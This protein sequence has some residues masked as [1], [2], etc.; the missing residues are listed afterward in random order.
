MPFPTNT[1]LTHRR[2]HGE[3]LYAYF[4]AL[5]FGREEFVGIQTA[6]LDFIDAGSTRYKGMDAYQAVQNGVLAL[7]VL[8][9]AFDEHPIGEDGERANGHCVATLMAKHLGLEQ[10]IALWP[11]TKHVLKNDLEGESS[12]PLDLCR[13]INDMHRLHPG[14]DEMVAKWALPAFEALYERQ[15]QFAEEAPKELERGLREVNRLPNRAG[16]DLVTVRSDNELLAAYAKS[17]NVAAVLLQINRKGQMI[18]HTNPTYRLDLSE[19]ACLLRRA[20]AERRNLPITK[21]QARLRGEGRLGDGIWHVFVDGKEG[22]ILKIMN[23][24]L[25]APNTEPT[26]LGM[27]EVLAIIR[28]GLA[29]AHPSEKTGTEGLATIG[30]RVGSAFLTP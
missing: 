19:V 21:D 13:V 3:E 27:K 23:G 9:G 26:L 12:G 20:E 1:V 28:A 30:E 14:K 18:V 7:G 11:M 22:R 5:T 15:R 24:S 17:K 25:T 16:Y 10:N 6:S 29:L 4:L 8:G 2:A